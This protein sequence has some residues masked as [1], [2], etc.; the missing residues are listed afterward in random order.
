[1][2]ALTVS[3]ETFRLNTE[4]RL[5]GGSHDP[6]PGPHLMPSLVLSWMRQFK[7]WSVEVST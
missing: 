5:F 2:L 7:C 3:Y 4:S 6:V 1:M